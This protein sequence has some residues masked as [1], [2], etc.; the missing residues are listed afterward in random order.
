MVDSLIWELV[1]NIVADK[2]RV[3]PSKQAAYSG[4]QEQTNGAAAAEDPPVITP[5]ALVEALRVLRAQIPDYTQI[6]P[7]DLKAIQLVANINPDFA[8]GAINDIER[9]SFYRT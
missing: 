7:A 1:W 4:N 9:A 5:E 6:P 2:L 8:Q 3:E